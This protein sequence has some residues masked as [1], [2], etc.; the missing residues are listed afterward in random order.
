M[1]SSGDHELCITC[2]KK[3]NLSWVPKCSKTLL[4]AQIPSRMVEA[5]LSCFIPKTCRDT[6]LTHS[7]QEVSRAFRIYKLVGIVDHVRPLVVHKDV[8]VLALAWSYR[9]TPHESVLFSVKEIPKLRW[10]S[11]TAGIKM[12]QEYTHLRPC[13]STWIILNQ[14]Q[15]ETAL[16][17]PRSRSTSWGYCTRSR[18][19]QRHGPC[20]NSKKHCSERE[21]AKKSERYKSKIVKRIQTQS[22][23]GKSQKTRKPHKVL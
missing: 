12:V 10:D 22:A 11:W 18:L 7:P 14:Y 4:A 3:H 9:S 19:A 21:S 20:R 15:T 8:L 13:A 6:C 16:G 5:V 23:I 1:L 2:V 17:L